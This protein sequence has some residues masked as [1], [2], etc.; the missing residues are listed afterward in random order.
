MASLRG[1]RKRGDLYVKIVVK[2]PKK[3]NQRQRELLEAFAETEDLALSNKKKS[4][5]GFWKK[6][7]K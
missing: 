2:I 7:T 3:A 4:P 6:M 5:K 1:Y